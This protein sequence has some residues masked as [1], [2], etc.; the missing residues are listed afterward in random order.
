MLDVNLKGVFLCG[1]A[2][3]PV[4]MTRRYGKI[5]NIGSLAGLRMSFFGRADYAASKHG[6]TGL[7]QHLAWE[8]ADYGIRSARAR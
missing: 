1:M 3:L 5:V 4:M 7:T 2:V 8:A 6:L